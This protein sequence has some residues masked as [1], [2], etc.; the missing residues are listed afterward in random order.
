MMYQHDVTFDILKDIFKMKYQTT[1]FYMIVIHYEIS[2]IYY[3]RS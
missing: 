2:Y 3:P 1:N